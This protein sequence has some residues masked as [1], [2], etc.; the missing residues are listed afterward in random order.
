MG[1]VIAEISARQEGLE[2]GAGRDTAVGRFL[3]QHKLSLFNVYFVAI[4]LLYWFGPDTKWYMLPT[5]L[6]VPVAFASKEAGF[7]ATELPNESLRRITLLVLSVMPFWSFGQG[8]LDA[9]QVKEGVSY[10]YV[11]EGSI[12]GVAVPDP[13][14]EKVRLRYIGHAN[15]YVFLLAPDKN[16]VV[17]THFDRI[18]TLHLRHHK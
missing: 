2:H 15:D 4:L 6:G 14:N 7:L 5:L 16:T 8:R 11:S 18:G 9:V 3:N 10:D 13:S 17:M 12:D 1:M